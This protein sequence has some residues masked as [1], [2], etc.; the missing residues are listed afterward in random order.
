[1]LSA[2]SGARLTVMTKVAVVL[3]AEVEAVTV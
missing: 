3:P 1:M 2:L